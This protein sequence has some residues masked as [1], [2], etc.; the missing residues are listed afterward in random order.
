MQWADKGEGN[1]NPTVVVNGHKGP[2]PLVIQAKAGENIRLDASKSKDPDRNAIQF[3][4]WQQP[5][6]GQTKIA[7]PDDKQPAV[8]ITIP[9]DAADQ[10]L[11]FVC[12]VR[13]NGFFS[14]KSY[15]RIIIVVEKRK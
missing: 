10:T 2:S 4:W 9:D 6:I 7:I 1:R 8:S 15:Q 13:D 14:L 5:E 3:H 11:H 12:E